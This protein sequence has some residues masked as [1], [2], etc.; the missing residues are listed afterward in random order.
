MTEATTVTDDRIHWPSLIAAISAITAVGIAIGLG[1]PLL[2][3]I[4]DKR[5]ISSS[6][7]GINSAMAGIAAMMA[8]PVTT[9][10]AH[11]FG[12]ATT[13]IWAIVIASLSSFGFYY[14]VNYWAWFPLQIVFHGATTALFILSEF[15]INVAAPPK[16]RGLI[17]GLYASILSVGFATGTLIFSLVGSEGVLPFIVGAGIILLAVIPI[18][19]ARKG[20]KK[21][22]PVGK[23]ASELLQVHRHRS[24]RHSGRLHLRRR[25]SGRSH[26]AAALCDSDRFHRSPGRRPA[27][28]DGNWQLRL[29][30]PSACCL[31]A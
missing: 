15:W 19:V 21:S 26:P 22:G 31:T 9:W 7:T 10:C 2:S 29:Q 13:M 6:L 8:A 12:V 20:E 25:R 16:R 1:L 27:D 18:F 30:I 5:G 3:L 28:R 14:I 11:R 23:P 4:L 17:L 24:D